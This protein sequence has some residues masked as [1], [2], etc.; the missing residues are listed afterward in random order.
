MKKTRIFILLGVFVVLVLAAL[1]I[2]GVG[3]RGEKRTAKASILF[4]GFDAEKVASVEIR[5]QEGEIKL[6]IENGIWVVATSDNYPADPK[7]VEDMLKKVKD[8]KSSHVASKSSEK[9]SQFEVDEKSGVEVKILDTE[10]K[11]LAHFFVGKMGPDFMSTYVRRIDDD[12]VLM[13]GEYLKSVFDKGT[14][15]WRDRTI[16]SFDATQVQ[17]LTLVSKEKGEIAVEANA[18]SGWQIVKP[19]VAPAKK[20]AVDGIV[21][22]LSNLSAD[23]F[24]EKKDLREYKLDQP[25]SK[26]IVDLKDGTSRVLLIGDKSDYRYYVKSQEKDDVFLLSEGKINSF[27]KDLK[28]LK[29]EP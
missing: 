6:K 29:A 5:T 21:S 15:G 8:M 9:H 23:D 27:F 17:R 14:R 19:E 2:E 12:K 25:Q 4:P 20:E 24:A 26:V 10:D 28:D 7:A 11:E 22:G 13:V 18:E 1:I 16:L 3:N